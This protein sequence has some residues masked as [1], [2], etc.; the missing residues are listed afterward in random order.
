M[1]VVAA[2]VAASP[3][4]DGVLDF[5]EE[6][7]YM[8]A[9][10]HD[11]LIV[12]ARVAG[13]ATAMLLARAGARVLVVDQSREG[14]DTLSTHAFMR[15]GIV[16]LSRWG[17]I[18]ELRAAGTPPVRRTVIR[19]G[20]HED[21]VEI[22]PTP[23]CDALYAPRRTTLD[24]LLVAAAR[25]A[26]A[27]VRFGVRVVG[28]LRDPAG[29][30]RG[31]RARGRDGRLVELRADVTIGADGLRSSIAREV[32]APIEV[33]GTH[34]TALVGGYFS[35]LDVDGY[36]WLYGE[37]MTG[38]IIPTDHGQVCA[39]IGIPS[40]DFARY[41]K[42]ADLGFGEIFGMLAPDWLDRLRRSTRHGPLRGFPGHPG[43]LR[44][45]WGDGWALVGDAGYFKDPLS[46]HGMTD[47][48]RDAELL[49]NALVAAAADGTREAEAAA[50]AGYQAQRDAL[51][52]DLFARVDAI[53]SY[54]WSL[55]ELPAQLVQLS[56]AMRPE[57]AHLLD[58]DLVS[59]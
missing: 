59:A 25:R 41:R 51:S 28:V 15:G 21:V 55:D 37:R 36:Q 22:K 56:H 16:Q 33:Q 13:A 48:L 14:S 52:H 35:G 5:T 27:E 2:E 18:D 7:L 1:W 49:T 24:P 29:R 54:D 4:R 43:F 45:P 34:A 38:G 46:T 12:G 32:Q 57:V 9:T 30:V 58:L 40:A 42:H 44:R 26:G 47:A 17:L 53:A 20:D 31:V 11:V 50:L 10:H 3:T 19:Y 23:H 8:D 39:W 6:D